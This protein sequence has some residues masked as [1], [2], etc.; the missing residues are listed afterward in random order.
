MAEAVSPTTRLLQQM[1]AGDAGAA[2]QLLPLVYDELRR[3]AGRLM[4][5]ER[6]GHTLQ[7]TALINE[8]F[9]R[10]VE[11]GAQAFGG[12]VHFLRVAA[13][14]MRN[15]LVDHARARR[16]A[17]R[18]GGGVRVTLD[19]GVAL[20]DAHVDGVLAVDETLQ[21][22]T[23]IDPQLGQIVEMRYFGGYTDQ[24]TAEALGVSLRTVERGWRLARAWLTR[25]MGKESEGGR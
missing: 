7:P 1:H 9:L 3:I 18:G 10:L 24:E 12:R 6:D 15:V 5:A 19:E 8:A 16:A 4:G 23:A 25:E 17:K 14:A 13:R 22:L 11:P 20:D 21:R 2:E